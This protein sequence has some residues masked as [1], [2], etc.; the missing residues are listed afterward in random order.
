MKCP[1]CGCQKFYVKDTDDAYETYGFDCASGAVYFDPDIDKAD[2]PEICDDSHI[3]CEKCAWN[4]RYE[5]IKI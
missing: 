2:I 3:Y 1:Y 4:G 5:E